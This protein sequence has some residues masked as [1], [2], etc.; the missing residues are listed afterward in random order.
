MQFKHYLLLTALISSLGQIALSLYARF[1]GDLALE[2]QAA[3]PLPVD[4]TRVAVLNALNFALPVGVGCI[5]LLVY[6][7]KINRIGV[8][9]LAFAVG[10]QVIATDLN[11]RAIR[12]VFGQETELSSVAWWAPKEESAPIEEEL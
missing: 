1:Y 2:I 7:W 10:L 12:H 5:A 11:L 4:Q 3:D 6:T 9:A 8:F